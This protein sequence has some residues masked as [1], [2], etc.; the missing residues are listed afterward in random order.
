L[1][2]QSLDPFTGGLARLQWKRIGGTLK[3]S[4]DI[5]IVAQDE[6]I[7]PVN[8]II[9]LSLPD[10]QLECGTRLNTTKYVNKVSK[11]T[12]TNKLIIQ[13]RSGVPK[14]NASIKDSTID[15]RRPAAILY[16]IVGSMPR[17][18]VKNILSKMV[19][20]G[21]NGVTHRL[22]RSSGLPGHGKWTRHIRLS[23]CAAW[24]PVYSFSRPRARIMSRII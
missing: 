18:K 16:F 19:K 3:R 10:V 2:D 24:Q 1:R 20:W 4:S 9:I 22:V 7:T 8:Q 21:Q 12:G 11:S 15:G 6:A 17:L 13:K 23:F 5:K 14:K